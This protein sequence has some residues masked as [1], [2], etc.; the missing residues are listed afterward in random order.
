MVTGDG[1]AVVVDGAGIPAELRAGC[2]HSVA[3]FAGSVANTL[4][5][6]LITRSSSMSE[7]LAE[8]IARVKASHVA[9]CDLAEGSPSATVA[10]WRTVNEQVEYI[11]L[12][13]ASIVLVEHHGH[14]IEI[15]DHRLDQVLGRVAPVEAKTSTS[16]G[17]RL[18]ASRRLAV[19][20]ARNKDGGFWCVHTEPDAAAE[21]I[22]GA[23][24]LAGLAG[25][26]ALSDGAARAYDL[27]N[28]R[29]LDEFASDALAGH[30]R[31]LS[32]DIRAE[33]VR[34][35]EVLRGQ[36][37]KVHDDFSVVAQPF[38]SDFPMSPESASVK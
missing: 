35:A 20:A 1:A 7:A 29:A 30:L 34:R 28:T 21:A 4:H 2:S 10:A 15:T 12:C 19:E 3:W 31:A 18:L 37:L 36:G 25:V 24:P 17:D 8:T 16:G 9:D 6:L 14:S 22:Q 5:G 23:V 32:D 11:V 33:E 38:P 26:L 13:D 27:L